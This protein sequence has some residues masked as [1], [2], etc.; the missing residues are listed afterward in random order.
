MDIN[1]NG[2]PGHAADGDDLTISASS[3]GTLFNVA[4]VNGRVEVTVNPAVNASTRDG[5]TITIDTGVDIATLEFDTNG[6]F[7]EDNF[8][9]RSI[10]NTPASI[11]AAIQRAIAE[12]PLRPAA[13]SVSGATVI[14]DG[15]DEDGVSF[16]SD[17]N[18]NGILNRS[19]GV[20]RVDDNGNLILDSNGNVA[21]FL[22][23]TVTG[24]GVLD[25]W[26]DFAADGDFTDVGDQII[27]GAI[28][29]GTGVEQTFYVPFPSNAP[30]PVTATDTYARFRVSRNGGLQPTG[31]ALSGEVEDYRLRLLPG[32]A[33]LVGNQQANRTYTVEENRPLQVLDSTGLLT[34]TTTGDNGILVGVTDAENNDIAV[35]APDVRQE[36]LFV[37]GVE[38]GVLDLRSDGT[39]TFLPAQDFNGQVTFSARV[40][41]VSPL[42]PTLE[43]LSARPIQVT[44][45]VTPVNNVPFATSN[46]PGLS[47][48]INED[49]VTTFTKAELIDPFYSP[50]PANEAN[51]PLI[52]Q[53]VGSVRGPFLSSL[54]G[55]IAISSDRQSLVYTPPVDYN[56]SQ[57]DTFTYFVADVPGAGQ[58][59]ETATTP[60]VVSISFNAVN[61]P[62]RLVNDTYTA[63]EDESL[64]IPIRS[65]DRKGILDNDAAG[66]ADEVNPP[67]S[68]TI[69]LVTTDFP[70]RTF[71]GGNVVLEN[72]SL[73]YTPPSQFSG[74]DQFNYTVRDN[75][76]A[77]STALVIINVGGENDAPE[78]IGINGNAN[79][80]SLTFDESKDDART[81]Q[82][83]LSTWFRDPEND[84]ISYTVTSSN[85][86]IVAARALADT[87]ILELPPFAF[88][89]ATLSITAVDTSGATVVTQVPVTVNDTPDPPTLVGTFNPLAGVEDQL[90]TATLSTVF[91]DPDGEPLTYTVA[92]I[93]NI[94]NPTASQIAQD[95][96]VQS[97][98]F[99]N[100]QM[101]IQLKPNQSGSVD[102]EIAASDG[103]FRISDAFTLTVAP[104]PDAPVA[105]NDA[106]NVPVGTELQ[107]LNPANGLLRN[108]TDADGDSLL[109]DL[110]SVTPSSPDF[111]VNADGTFTFK[112]TSGSVGQQVTF[113]YNVIDSTGSV[114]NTATVTFTF[115]QSRYQ[116]PIAS[117]VADVNAD[118]VIS[119]L[120][121]LRIINLL[122]QRLSGT[123]SSLAVSEIGTPPPDY[124]DVSGDGRVSAFDA[125]LVINALELRGS[126]PSG[127]GESVASG[128]FVAEKATVSTDVN[129]AATVSYASATDT[130]L[131]V[132]NAVAV[133]TSPTVQSADPRD[134][135]LQAGFEIERSVVDNVVDQ[136]GDSNRGSDSDDTSSVD[137]AMASLL[138]DSF[139]DTGTA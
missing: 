98:G 45:N 15:D 135:I 121:A 71:R 87:L 119:A 29:N 112:A 28:L 84:A 16:V 41:D 2:I 94:L 90:V 104:R 118:G 4:I 80:T 9:I 134:A 137:L 81:V 75:L 43:L 68:Q 74:V 91:A 64:I 22:P 111:V 35:Y 93:R 76:Q 32:T 79:E 10:D 85:S 47:R 106:Y 139:I 61:D 128:E 8:A 52:F 136:F 53:S 133:E 30:N 5:D 55:I 63:N 65:A 50:G 95:P 25:A 42:D 7:D 38:A 113:S 103:S 20:T 31:L 126:Q 37:S 88:G 86:S 107:V 124:V 12:S 48:Q 39:F 92:R 56:G 72:G 105:G 17:L 14:I 102:L 83:D 122:D 115:N 97:V 132:R 26:I 23:I 3:T 18:P 77:S 82:F 117:L 138:E 6:R 44:I 1:A 110:N 131:P 89:A 120:D 127:S 62:P 59:P 116:N 33:P 114:S 36:T 13:V 99:V 130:N 54:G 34:P 49:T 27:S 125:L 66:P 78:F 108:D 19:V 69:S 57:A 40:T 129:L 67:Q 11:A 70:Q 96:L 51:Q 58:T 123:S 109:I 60:G 46:N 21:I 24:S 73:R 101:Q 100:G